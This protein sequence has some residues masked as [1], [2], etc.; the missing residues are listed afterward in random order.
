MEEYRSEQPVILGLFNRRMVKPSICVADRKQHIRR[1][2]RNALEE[3]DVITCECADSWEI[4]GMLKTR[5]VDLVVLG[6]SSI[7]KGGAEMLRTLAANRFAGKV[8][9]LGPRAALDGVQEFGDRIGLTMLP[10]LRTPFVSRS[11]RDRVAM[12][13]DV[14]GHL[15]VKRYHCGDE[16]ESNIDTHHPVS[17][18]RTG[19]RC[20]DEQ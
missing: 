15:S 17:A 1:F 5:L 9:L 20:R 6:P 13:L 12:V 3:F 11:L 7:Q 19:H 8:L 18:A 14:M 16:T 4:D 10:A 2:V